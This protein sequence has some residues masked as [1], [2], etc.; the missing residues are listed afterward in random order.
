MRKSGKK[1]LHMSMC[2][3]TE[4]LSKSEIRSGMKKEEVGYGGK[5]R[6]Y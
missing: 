3:I 5:R 4:Y 6:N 2:R 1:I